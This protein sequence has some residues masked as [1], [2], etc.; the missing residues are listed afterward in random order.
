MSGALRRGA[1]N[2]IDEE[3]VDKWKWTRSPNGSRTRIIRPL[4]TVQG[5]KDRHW[6]SVKTFVTTGTRR[7]QRMVNISVAQNGW[8]L[9]SADILSAFPQG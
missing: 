4:L 7:G 3:W 6:D 1:N 2:L 9:Y 5:F 8:K